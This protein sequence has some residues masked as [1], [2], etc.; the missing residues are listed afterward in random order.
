[1]MGWE[2]PLMERHAEA[3]LPE[4]ANVLNV[5]F[6]LGLVDGFL[7]ERG[8]LSHTIIEAHPDVLRK[9]ESLGWLEKKGVSVYRGRWQ[10]V[11]GKLPSESFDAIYFDTWNETYNDVLEFQDHVQ[12]LLR[13]G[14]R[15]SFFN[16]MAPYSIFEHTT[17][18]R[19]AQEDLLEHGLVC[20]FYPLKIGRLDDATWEGVVE[21]YWQFDTYYLPL[22]SLKGS[23]GSAN[24]ERASS[25]GDV[26]DAKLW[27]RWPE[28]PVK[29]SDKIGVRLPRAEFR[30]K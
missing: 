18:C 25:Q 5:G 6:G 13:E 22:A 3:L 30:L 4:G 17:F 1:M 9:M 19:L 23:K 20:D 14:G 8:P 27:R 29:V 10:D 28:F 24:I 21:R 26:L 12:R 15:F 11:I 16:G 7:A 2:G